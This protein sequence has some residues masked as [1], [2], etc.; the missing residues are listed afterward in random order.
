MVVAILIGDVP[1]RRHLS[2][3]GRFNG[4]PICRFC[5]METKSAAYY[6]L[7]RGVGSSAL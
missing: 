2:I 1:V 6:L 4:D 7:L 3:M 5:R